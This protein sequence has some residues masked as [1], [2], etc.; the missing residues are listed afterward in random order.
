MA[1][2]PYPPGY[3][4]NEIQKLQQ[5]NVTADVETAI[6]KAD[7]RFL[8]VVGFSGDVPGVLWNNEM[9]KQHG[10]RILDGT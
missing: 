3:F 7:Y 9:R 5:A 6:A 10:T 4:P 2:N 8:L 1:P